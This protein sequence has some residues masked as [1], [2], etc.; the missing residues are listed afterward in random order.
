[1]QVKVAVGV[2]SVVAKHAQV[3]T[4]VRRPAI[5]GVLANPMLVAS[6]HINNDSMIL[7]SGGS[8]IASAFTATLMQYC[9]LALTPLLCR[10]PSC[11]QPYVV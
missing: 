4:L 5:P 8:V 9:T 3:L 2:A 10:S 1:M 11:G 6:L 7:D